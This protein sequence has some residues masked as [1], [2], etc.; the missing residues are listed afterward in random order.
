MTEA[1]TP[2]QQKGT[3]DLASICPEIKRERERE[4]SLVDSEPATAGKLLIPTLDDQ[5]GAPRR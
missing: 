5:E 2:L 3:S 1:K 4:S